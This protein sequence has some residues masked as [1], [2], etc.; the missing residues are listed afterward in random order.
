MKKLQVA[1]DGPVSSGKS[2]VGSQAASQLG[3]L[4]IDTGLM[5][6]AVAWKIQQQFG[7]K[8]QWGEI[9]SRANMEWRGE[10]SSPS[11]FVDGKEVGAPL[12][13]PEISLLSSRIATDSEVRRALVSVQKEMAVG[14]GV[15]MVGRDI[16]TVV[17]PD[18]PIKIFLTGSIDVRATRRYAELKARGVDVTR[19]EVKKELIERDRVDT[20][21]E[22]SPLRPADDSVL[23][24]STNFTQAEVVDRIV[25]A[26]RAK[27][28]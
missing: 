12:Y 14:G 10:S 22:D 3:Y 16:G 4:F 28:G 15:V 2:T 8:K 7:A 6:R 5:Y 19:E 23:I 11:L 1:M 20:S 9:A 18:A 21:R 24:D 27:G 13:Y 26:V 25:S 17:L